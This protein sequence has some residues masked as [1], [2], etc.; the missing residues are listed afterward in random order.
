M[1][2]PLA[3]LDLLQVTLV[4]KADTQFSQVV[5]H[6]SVQTVTGSPSTLEDFADGVESRFAP[7][8]KAMMSSSAQWWGVKVQRLAPLKSVAVL[9]IS[10][11][12][13]A[14]VDGDL[15]PRQA[16]G[17]IKLMTATGSRSARGRSFIPFASETHNNSNGDP[18]GAYITLL[19][20]LGDSLIQDLSLT[21][22]GRGSTSKAVVFSRKLN[23]VENLIARQ[24]RTHWGSQRRRS[25]IGRP[26]ADP[27]ST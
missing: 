21:T 10:R 4:C 8:F 1:A 20:S 24:S 14:D 5:R 7:L 12:D 22:G 3:S 26:D 19:D 13:D 18:E 17:V 25:N 9:S 27:L 23:A 15:I 16:C 11:R 2:I 6:Y